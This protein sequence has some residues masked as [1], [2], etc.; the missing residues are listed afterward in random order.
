MAIDHLKNIKNM[1]PL[2]KCLMGM[3]VG[4]KTIGIAVSD[5]NNKIATP[6][7]TIKRKKL[8][9]DIPIIEDY[10]REFNIGGFV[11]G[12][13]VNMDGT[14]GR[15]CQSV[16]D[17]AYE[18]QRQISDEFKNDGEIIIA[19]WDER[20]ST[21]SVEEIVGKHVEKRSRRV[22]AKE[23]GLIDKLAAMLILQGA[24]DYIGRP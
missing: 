10:A 24:L 14:E 1:L 7:T 8:S 20:L 21:S 3:D 19:L 18:L 2:G 4:K 15:R 12:L 23:S 9:K 16:R 11:I 22:N 17:F 5:Q 6:V 13:P